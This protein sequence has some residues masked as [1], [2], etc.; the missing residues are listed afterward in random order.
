MWGRCVWSEIEIKANS[1]QLRLELGQSLA[2]TF[3]CDIAE[4]VNISLNYS[5]STVKPKF[6]F[7]IVSECQKLVVFSFGGDI[8]VKEWMTKINF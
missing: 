5:F 2:T 6:K 3:D 7:K 4:P 8:C 1:A